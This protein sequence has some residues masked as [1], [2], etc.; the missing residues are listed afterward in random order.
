MCIRDRGEYDLEPGDMA[1]HIEEWAKSGFL[2]VVGGCCGSSPD[3][4]RA[5]ANAVSNV[6]PRAA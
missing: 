1:E 6:V 4:I 2:N 5:I 3:H